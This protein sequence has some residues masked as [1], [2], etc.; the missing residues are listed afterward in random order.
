MHK[1]F[2]QKCMFKMIDSLHQYRPI[3][4][5][6]DGILDICL[7]KN[8]VKKKKIAIYEQTLPYKINQ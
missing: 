8:I 4:V 2:E 1:C 5:F 3:H 7:F 6:K